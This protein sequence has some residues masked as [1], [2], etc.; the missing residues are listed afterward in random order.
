M[1][2][3]LSS[4]AAWSVKVAVGVLRPTGPERLTRRGAACQEAAPRLTNARRCIIIQ[5]MQSTRLAPAT[6]L[7]NLV[8]STGATG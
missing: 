4:M 6:V 5:S 1:S 2:P 8:R 7:L 3:V